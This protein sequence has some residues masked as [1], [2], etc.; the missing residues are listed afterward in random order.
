MATEHAT[1]A[2]RPGYG[3]GRTAL[4]NAAIRVGA[5]QGL[6]RLTYRAVA[7]EAGVTHGLVA[8]HFGSRDALLEEA[9]TH[10]IDKSIDASALVADTHQVDDFLDGLAGMVSADPDLQ[11][12]QYELILEARSRPELR[13]HAER[14][15]QT[16]LA[17]TRKGLRRLGIDDE[18]LTH[19]V[20]AAADGL[21][22]H[23][24]TVGTEQAT[25]TGIR[26]LQRLLEPHIRQPSPT[27]SPDQPQ[28]KRRRR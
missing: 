26:Q 5:R 3:E 8:H 27:R 17:A 28:Q 24:V 18:N 14:L 9:L 11:A 1:T 23:Q 21:V 13:P 7:D 12:F 10:S 25:R 16:Y 19:L 20:Y 6:R 4:L 22:F 15:Y 2:A